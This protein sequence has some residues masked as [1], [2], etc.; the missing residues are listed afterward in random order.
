MRVTTS[1]LR[2]IVNKNLSSFEVT[3][4]VFVKSKKE[5]KETEETMEAIEQAQAIAQLAAQQIQRQ[6]HDKIAGVVSRCLETVFGEKYEFQIIF[7]RKRGKTEARLAFVK[8]GEELDGVSAVGGGVVDVASFALRLS[9]LVLSTPAVRRVMVLDEPF[10]WLSREYLGR[11][12]ELLQSLA[13]EMDVQFIMVTHI[14]ELQ[15]GK[16][17]TLK[18]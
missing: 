1:D 14:P 10:K 18:G 17:V 12:A 2:S 6:A 15:M 3:K 16:V 13:E 4:Q 9:C 8:D 7:E 11:V 5:L